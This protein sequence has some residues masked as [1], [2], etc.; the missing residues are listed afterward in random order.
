MAFLS[1]HTHA[2]ACARARMHART[3]MH[4]GTRWWIL[5]QQ[6][7][8]FVSRPSP[9]HNISLLLMYQVTGFGG[10]T[11]VADADKALKMKPVSDS[12]ENGASPVT[13]HQR[14]TQVL[15]ENVAFSHPVLSCPASP[16][17]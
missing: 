9:S 8:K 17:L 4:R 12:S 16:S 11:Q 13:N 5:K 2:R 15:H 14:W 6:G 3:H 1:T 10:T 7:P